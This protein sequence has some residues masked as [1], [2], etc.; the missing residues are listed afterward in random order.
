MG[1]TTFEKAFIKAI[2]K[3]FDETK[4]MFWH[5]GSHTWIKYPHKNKLRGIET[6]RSQHYIDRW[7]PYFKEFLKTGVFDENAYWQIYDT[8]PEDST[9]NIYI[10]EV[11]AIK[12]VLKDKQWS[13]HSPAMNQWM[14][15]VRIENPNVGFK[16]RNKPTGEEHDN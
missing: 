3:A 2:G 15:A 14:K 9:K 12:M 10:G 4:V 5:K 6:Y 1:P 16:Q 11:R 7:V 8:D 13:E